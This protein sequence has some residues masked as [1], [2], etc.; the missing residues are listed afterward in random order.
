[1][2]QNIKKVHKHYFFMKRGQVSIDLLITLIIVVMVIGAF[3]ILLS[4]F[5]SGQ[6]EFFL[7]TQLRENSSTLASFIT[8][9]N[10]ISDTNFTT[11]LMIHNINYKNI[12]K[13]P[14]VSINQNYIKLAF[15]TENGL[16]EEEAFFSNPKDSKVTTNGRLLVVS[17]E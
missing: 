15:E 4:S 7:R 13:Q 10:A 6:E 12:S 17:N 2:R 11:K 16:I 9:T 14:L 3:T 5:K 8:S 1:M